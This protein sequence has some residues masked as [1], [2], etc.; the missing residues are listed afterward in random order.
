MSAENE[1]I[2]KEMTELDQE[3]GLYSEPEEQNTPIKEVEDVL[4]GKYF[5]NA[6]NYIHDETLGVAAS[7]P[8]NVIMAKN[9]LIK[10]TEME[11]AHYLKEAV[12]CDDWWDQKA[13]PIAQLH[14]LRNKALSSEDHVGVITYTAMIAARDKLDF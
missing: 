2:L 8:P 5:K 11:M 6:I 3:M 4:A 10:S 7:T 9:L 12:G 13:I 14:Y 1:D